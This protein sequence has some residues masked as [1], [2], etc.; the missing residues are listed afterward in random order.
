MTDLITKGFHH[1]TMVSGNAQR[2]VK[3]YRDLLGLGLVKRTVNF[4]DPTAYH[5]YFGQERGA[6][7]TLLTFFE[8]AGLPHGRPGIGGVHHVAL[9]VADEAALLKWKR[10]LN[11]HHVPTTGPVN[12]GYFKSLYF[13][14]PD[15]QIL[16]LATKGPGY[17]IDEPAGA[18]GQQVMTPNDAQL[19]RSPEGRLYAEMTHAEPV[20]SIGADMAIDGIHHISAITA[21]TERADRFYSSALGLRRI[22]KSVNQDALNMP[23]HFWANYDGKTVGPHSGWTLFGYPENWNRVRGGV[24]QTH[25]V[26]FRAPDAESQAAWREALVAAGVGV[27]PVMERTYFKSIY[28]QDPDGL[29]LEIATDDPGFAVD[30]DPSRL[31]ESLALPAWLEGEREQIERSLVPIV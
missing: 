22:K 31:G 19:Q 20:A 28:F 23:H 11:D 29:L 12:R 27:S 21:D 5:L 9:G 18:L 2:T 8:W 30:E 10:W 14:D 17:A 3:F 24:G 6:P 15:G 13:Q 1:V 26:A 16:E 4:D 7:G 25:H